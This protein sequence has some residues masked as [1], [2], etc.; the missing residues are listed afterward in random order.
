MESRLSGRIWLMISHLLDRI[1]CK[2]SK[3]DTW[4]EVL[5]FIIFGIIWLFSVISKA[6][7][8]KT[9]KE[10][11]QPQPGHAPKPHQQP[12]DLE[13]FVKMVK[14]RYA[15]AREQVKKAQQREYT[16]RT[17]TPAPTSVQPQIT[18]PAER[19]FEPRPAPE[20]AKVLRTP[21]AQPT[22]VAEPVKPQL[23]P[24]LSDFNPVTPDF[25][26]FK[27]SNIL[28][29]EHPVEMTAIDH[30]IYEQAV[31]K[32]YLPDVM[33][34]FA[35]PDGQRKAF[36]FGEIFGKPIGLRDN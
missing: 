5:P 29:E 32:P 8:S 11:Q 35:S 14:D 16:E 36:L 9:G 1:V 25:A 18:R 30:H 10:N 13:D 28:E 6:L 27:M 22:P 12:G 7:Q 4:M 3:I 15:E 19:R 34:Q 26:D 24:Q 20:P 31:H 21:A 17:V 2:D 33:E 23:E